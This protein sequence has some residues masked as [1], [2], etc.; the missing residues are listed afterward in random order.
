MKRLSLSGIRGLIIG[1]RPDCIDEE[2]LMY[3]KELSTKCYLAVEYGVES[4]YNK[5]LSRV[6]RGHTFEE[7][8]MAIEKSAS[9]SGLIPQPILFWTSRRNP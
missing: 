8:V 4:C 1:T 3:L 6:N 5:T 2:N 9:I 7:A